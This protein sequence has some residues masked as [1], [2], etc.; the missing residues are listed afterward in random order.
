MTD[1]K[2][3]IKFDHEFS[4]D[5]HMAVEKTFSQMLGVFVQS[6]FTTHGGDYAVSGS[7]VMGTVSMVEN[8]VVG[9]LVLC[10]PKATLFAVLKKLYRKD[11][12]AVDRT[13]TLAVGELTNV[14]FGVFKHRQSEKGSRY[15]MA[16]PQIT[17]SSQ[18]RMPGAAATLEGKFTS[19]FGDFSAYVVLA[20]NR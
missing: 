5:I 11:F 7:D 3:P 1:T 18:F 20:D 4:I 6:S 17:E 10:F 16:I 8:D 14:I 12:T 2:T 19:S 13:A 15:K 9:S